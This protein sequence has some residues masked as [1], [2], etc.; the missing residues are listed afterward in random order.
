MSRVSGYRLALAPLSV[1][2]A[3]SPWLEQAALRDLDH[4]CLNLAADEE[5]LLDDRLHGEPAIAER[6]ELEPGEGFWRVKSLRSPYDSL[7]ERQYH[8]LSQELAIG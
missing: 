5:L 2:A 1:E 3:A 8:T 6:C 4:G 7:L